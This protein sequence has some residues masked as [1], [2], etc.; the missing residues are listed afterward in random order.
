MQI[1]SLS[2]LP[3]YLPLSQLEEARKKQLEEQKKLEAK[4]HAPIQLEGT[5]EEHDEAQ[6]TGQTELSMEGVAGVGSELERVHIAE[7]N[8]AMAAKLKVSMS[9]QHVAIVSMV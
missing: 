6:V 3:S 4:L 1:I 7:K 9:V 8:K 5:H 2:L